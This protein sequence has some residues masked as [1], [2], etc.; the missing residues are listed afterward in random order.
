MKK[1][2]T[3]DLLGTLRTIME[4][5]T[6]H[7]QSD[8]DL[9]VKTL[10]DVARKAGDTKLE[11]RIFLWMVRTCGTWCVR[12]RNVFIR[13]SWEY[14]IWN[15][16]EDQAD[17][18]ILAYRIEVAGMEGEKVTGSVCELNYQKHC[19]YIREKAISASQIKLIYEKGVLMQSAGKRIPTQE[20]PV[21]GKL[22]FFWII[23]DNPEQLA[24]LLYEE[25]RKFKKL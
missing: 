21:L 10:T 7:Y 20:D 6:K 11:D 1:F 12:E 4:A 24:D 9:D 22:K 17:R 8:F 15:Y 2:V 25:Y 14:A 5:H 19:R 16:Y 13:D 23:P 18:R 3:P